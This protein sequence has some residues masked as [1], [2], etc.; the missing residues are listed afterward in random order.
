[1]A[2]GSSP[3]P[4]RFEAAT[5]PPTTRRSYNRLV[6]STTLAHPTRS[7][8]RV[9]LL[10]AALALTPQAVI[11]QA[12]APATDADRSEQAFARAVALH[13]TGDILGAIDAYQEALRLSPGRLDARSNL[14]VALAHLGRFD[15][16]VEQ[17]R[18]A[19]EIDPAQ[20]PIRFNLGL[21]LYKAGRVP[22]AATV[23][24]QVL[25][26]DPS[27]KSALLLLADCSLQQGNDARTIELLSPREKELGDDHLFAYLLGTAYVRQGDLARGQAL[28]DRLFRNGESAEGHLLLGGQYLRRGDWRRALPE[29][30]RAVEMNSALPGAHSLYGIALTS[31]GDRPAAMA[32]FRRELQANPNDFD[33]NLRLGLLLRDEN[34][35]DTAADYVRRAARLR[36]QHPDVLY[37][38]ARIHL[39]Q[40]NLEEARKAL[41]SLT[42]AVSGYENGHVL[43]ATVYYRLNMKEQGDHERAIVEK[44]KAERRQRG[45]AEAEPNTSGEGAEAKP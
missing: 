5:A 25:E 43:L 27:H 28:I 22:E 31:S 34:K 11:A 16:A 42:A 38:L 6:V 18:K 12:A 8:L 36:P 45:G 10:L 37:A 13:Q 44:L 24:Q 19:L 32:A 1:V 3:P 9:L 15:E 17:Y 20:V 41:E 21:A 40:D 30:Q 35:V 39:A 2:S 7:S 33:A 4:F 23:F 14:G 29:L 26:G